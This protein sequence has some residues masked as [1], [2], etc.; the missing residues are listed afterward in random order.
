MKKSAFGGKS[1]E[2]IICEFFFLFRAE[3][4]IQAKRC[5]PHVVIVL[6]CK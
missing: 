2:K 3:R 6:V 4:K 1:E 5:E